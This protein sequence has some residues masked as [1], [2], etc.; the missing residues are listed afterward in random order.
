M[1]F[2]NNKI[3]KMMQEDNDHPLPPEMDWDSMKNGI[4]E[5]MRSMEQNR[6]DPKKKRDDRKKIGFFLIL[7]FALAIGLLSICRMHSKVRSTNDD[8]IARSTEKK[9]TNHADNQLKKTIITIPE[10][11]SAK[12]LTEKKPVTGEDEQL[13][14]IHETEAVHHSVNPKLKPN[15][16]TSSNY[17]GTTGSGIKA[18]RQT[19]ENDPITT[20]LNKKTPGPAHQSMQTGD[21][22]SNTTIQQTESKGPIQ[23]PM[24]TA[25]IASVQTQI[26]NEQSVLV[27]EAASN[28]EHALPQIPM[29]HLFLSGFHSLDLPNL[30][31]TITNSA[32]LERKDPR[33]FPHQL[34]QEGGVTFWSEGYGSN[35]PERERYEAPLTSLQ[36]QGHY[37]RG[38]KENYFVMAGLQYQQLESR[39]Q[40]NQTIHD[41]K[42]ILKDTII[43]VQNNLLTGGQKVIR[44]DV[45]QI[46]QAERRVI[47]HN[48]TKLF[49]ISF[50]LGK[51]WRFRSFQTDVYLGCAF[52][53]LV[54]NQG[55]S[56]YQ[57]TIVD[58]SG[59]D[60][61]LFQNQW[62]A[63]GFIGARLHYFLNPK[64]SLTSGFQINKSLL[65]WN[66]LNEVNQYPVSIGFQLGLG[67]HMP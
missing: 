6:P 27:P 45:E 51:S 28:M 20:L 31:M 49:K 8:G 47:H 53:S 10:H 42:V 55:R 37:M 50:G 24:N 13:V 34:L 33:R 5:K 66:N 35:R 52:N 48:T 26:T 32:Y 40:Y 25:D 43:Q 4:F 30:D 15:Q 14:S 9:V 38:F 44:G 2:N 12:P 3:N 41:H 36:L 67:Y 11:A 16:K 22:V 7:F 60:N 46:V 58:Y 64:L 63:D 1:E 39:L 29:L 62:A 59:S 61:I 19:N 54:K 23:G 57:G 21:V 56:V 17:A 18:A 65:D